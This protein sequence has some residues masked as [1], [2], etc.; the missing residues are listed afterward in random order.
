M[1]GSARNRS[2]IA[3][4]SPLI[5]NGKVSEDFSAQQIISHYSIAEKS[6]Y[7]R[8]KKKKKREGMFLIHVYSVIQLTWCVFLPSVM[9]SCLFPIFSYDLP[10]KKCIAYFTALN[11]RC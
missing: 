1:L 2:Q 4:I 5:Q 9:L 10:S 7:F 3:N 6:R 11:G 8:G